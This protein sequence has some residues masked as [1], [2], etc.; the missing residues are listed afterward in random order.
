MINLLKHN[1]TLIIIV[2]IVF[3]T[4]CN[5]AYDVFDVKGVWYFGNAFAFV[6][7]SLALM[8]EKPHFITEVLFVLC[9]GQLLD[10][11]IGIPLQVSLFEYI[12]LALYFAYKY[13]RRWKTT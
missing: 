5:I 3:Y 12:I 7:Y 10:E 11:L 1:T 2:G 8:L 6:C 13:I 4:G 9:V